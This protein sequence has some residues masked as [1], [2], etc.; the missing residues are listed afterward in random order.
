MECIIEGCKNKRTG[1]GYGKLRDVCHTHHRRKYPRNVAWLRRRQRVSRLRVYGLTK[2][3]FGILLDEQNNCCAVCGE[4]MR[5]PQVDHCHKS[6]QVRGLLCNKCN[7]GLGMFNDNIDLLAS[8]V[9]Y[10][11]NNENTKEIA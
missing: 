11:R 2:E 5:K 10:L 4:V 8:A 9:S 6:G 7:W 3:S 1:K